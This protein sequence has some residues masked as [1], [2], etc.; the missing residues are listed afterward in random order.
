MAIDA[1]LYVC[2]VFLKFL[3]TLA[4]GPSLISQIYYTQTI[5]G[6]NIR[7]FAKLTLARNF[8]FVLH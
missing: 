4:D 5:L 1:R 6:T 3:L 7:F 2:G 8:F